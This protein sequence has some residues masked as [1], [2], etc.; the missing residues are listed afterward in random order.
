MS[1][2][3]KFPGYLDLGNGHGDGAKGYHHACKH[4][5]SFKD[6]ARDLSERD[7]ERTRR[8]HVKKE[9]RNNYRA[10]VLS[11]RHGGAA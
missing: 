5:R 10:A 11:L 1:N 9:G 4:Y 6:L 3:I 8:W 7:L 2:V